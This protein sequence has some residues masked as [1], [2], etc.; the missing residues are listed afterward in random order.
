MI[1]FK[2]P[3]S[4]IALIPHK[5][6]C[7]NHLVTSRTYAFTFL[8]KTTKSLFSQPVGEQRLPG[9]DRILTINP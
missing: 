3:E 5:S 8:S 1:N 2:V 7:Y 6:K 4:E 9:G